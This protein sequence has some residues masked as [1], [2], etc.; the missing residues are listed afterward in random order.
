MRLKVSEFRLK[1]YPKDFT[2]VRAFYEKTLGLPIIKEWDKGE[3]NQGVMFRVGSTTFELLSPEGEPQPV[4]GADVSWEVADVWALYESFK[5][6]DNVIHGLRDNDWGD[7]SFRIRD[8]EGFEITFF[9][10]HKVSK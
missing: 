7:T 3:N 5:A 9:T 2:T 4:A 10:K 6:G 1:L 8:P